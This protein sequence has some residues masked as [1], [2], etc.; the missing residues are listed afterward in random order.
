MTDQEPGSTEP[1]PAP[2]PP[3][4][5][6]TPTGE[7]VPHGTPK[8]TPVGEAAAKAEL[9]RAARFT[10]QERQKEVD[11][12]YRAPD[13]PGEPAETQVGHK[14]SYENRR[15]NLIEAASELGDDRWVGLLEEVEEKLAVSEQRVI[16]LERELEQA[17]SR[18]AELEAQAE[19][20]KAPETAK[21]P[22][23]EMVRDIVK[24][25]EELAGHSIEGLEGYIRIFGSIQQEL[26]DIAQT[27][28]RRVEPGQRLDSLIETNMRG[29]LDTVRSRVRVCEDN[30]TAGWNESLRLRDRTAELTGYFAKYPQVEARQQIS[31]DMEFNIGKISQCSEAEY[32]AT[33]Q[34]LDNAVTEIDA[35][36]REGQVFLEQEGNHATSAYRYFIEESQILRRKLEDLR[37]RVER[38]LTTE[39]TNFAR[40]SNKFDDNLKAYLAAYPGEK[41]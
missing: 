35:Y 20:I 25:T 17:N 10:D 13:A 3:L 19:K 30:L 16:L 8:T 6:P 14:Q 2:Q 28:A 9:E 24:A 29:M 22:E 18:L 21:A 31:R 11:I 15:Q 23:H 36:L 26:A 39:R 5:P 38:S 7:Q 12:L 37:R 32:G 34:Q 1:Q 41:E 40:S 4:A 27:M 33:M